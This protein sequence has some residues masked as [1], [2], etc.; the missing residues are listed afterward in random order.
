MECFQ[1]QS[2]S[3]VAGKRV[4]HT[5][6]NGNNEK[7]PAPSQEMGF[8]HLLRGCSA[9]GQSAQSAQAEVPGRE[10]V[11]LT[12]SWQVRRWQAHVLKGSIPSSG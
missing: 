11:L 8:K 3:C 12:T 2:Q 5:E 7:P 9:H 4:W 6:H 1:L 10:R